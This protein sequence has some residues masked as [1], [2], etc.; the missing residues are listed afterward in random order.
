MMEEISGRFGEV[1]LR[2]K[3]ENARTSWKDAAEIEAAF[4]RPQACR[5]QPQTRP[6][7]VMRGERAGRANYAAA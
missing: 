7:R 5:G 1:A 6:R 2:R 4:S 3:V